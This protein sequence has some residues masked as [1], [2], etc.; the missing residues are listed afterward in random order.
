MRN[1]DWTPEIRE[2]DGVEMVLVP[3][4]CFMMGSND[5][6]DDEQPVHEQCFDE[7]YWIDRYE[8]TQGDF[9]RLGGVQA[10][11]SRFDGA[12]R[13]VELITWFEA[14]DFCE[15]RGGRLP[16]ERE[17]EYAAR[18]PD[19]LVYPWGDTWDENR[20]VWDGN[21]G[22]QTASVGSRPDGVSWVGAEDMSGNVWEWVSSVYRDYPYGANSEDLSGDG[23]RYM[24]RG[25]SWLFNNPSGLRASDRGRSDPGNYLNYGGFRCARS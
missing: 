1:A 3:S 15:L 17:W 19:G 25:G 21:S 8:V 22:N 18:G 7:P 23:E 10:E 9:A 6:D 14:R 4:G 11:D 12:N 13:P 24:L 20:V 2:F 16:T 5:G